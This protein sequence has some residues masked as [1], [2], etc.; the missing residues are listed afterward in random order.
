M[1]V[2][3]VIQTA[4]VQLAVDNSATRILV[5]LVVVQVALVQILAMDIVKAQVVYK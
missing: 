5:H 4:Q 1:D 2:L 3:E